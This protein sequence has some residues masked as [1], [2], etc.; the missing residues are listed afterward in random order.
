MSD[1]NN[2]RK[3][4][5]NHKING[6]YLSFPNGN[7]LST[8]W[9]A[10]TYSDNHDSFDYQMVFKEGSDT[11][12]VMPDCSST[13]LELIHAKF[14]QGSGSVIGYLTFEQWLEVL[15]ILNTHK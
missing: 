10:G 6:V 3:A 5:S 2:Q 14:D 15:N 7:G 13:V 8:I 12:E 1:R 9:G 4:F 11:C